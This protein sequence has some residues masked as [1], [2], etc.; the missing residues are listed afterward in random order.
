MHFSIFDSLIDPTILINTGGIIQYFNKAATE[1]FGY[2]SDDVVG[3]NVKI[4]MNAADRQQHDFYLANYLK[5]GRSKII[6]TGRDVLAVCKDGSLVSIHLGVNEHAIGSRRFFIGTMRRSVTSTT[7]SSK[8]LLEEVREVIDNLVL[9]G[10]IIDEKGIVQGFNGAAAEIFG[11]SLVEIVGQN[12]KKLMPS[13]FANEHDQYV[14][15]YLTTGVKKI[16][17]KERQVVGMTKDGSYLP[18]ILSITEKREG[19]KRVFIGMLRPSNS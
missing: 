14:K 12:V 1:M 8:T 9:P 6:G 2:K 18:L 16:I 11:Y 19:T 10:V 13:Q 5:T 15:N 3:Q 4:L 17:G 7:H